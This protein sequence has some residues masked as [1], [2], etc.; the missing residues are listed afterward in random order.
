MSNWIPV[1]F[2]HLFQI[3]HFS[4]WKHLFLS[5]LFDPILPIAQSEIHILFLY[6]ISQKYLPKFSTPFF[7]KH[8]YLLAFKV[9]YSIQIMELPNQQALRCLCLFISVATHE[10]ILKMAFICYWDN[11]SHCQALGKKPELICIKMFWNLSQKL[12]TSNQGFTST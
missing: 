10:A 12:P 4:P 7:L 9:T 2:L 1:G 8:S 11:I 5:W 3:T 6:L